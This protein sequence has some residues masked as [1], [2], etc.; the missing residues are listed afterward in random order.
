MKPIC[1]NCAHFFQHVSDLLDPNVDTCT[2]FYPN[3]IPNDIF[4]GEVGHS[5]PHPLQQN[6][7]ILY[8]PMS[9]YIE[10]AEEPEGD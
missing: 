4:L 2:A 6:R 10:E 9:P 8:T 3:E 7:D 5:V 1:H